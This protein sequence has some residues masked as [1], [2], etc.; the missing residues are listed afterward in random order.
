MRS[1]AAGTGQHDLAVALQ[2]DCVRDFGDTGTAD[3]N[4]F[5]AVVAK[6]CIEEAVRQQPKRTNLGRTSRQHK[7]LASDHDLAIRLD[8]DGVGVRRVS[9]IYAGETFAAQPV[10]GIKV[11]RSR[12]SGDGQRPAAIAA[13]SVGKRCMGVNRMSDREKAA[14]MLFQRQK[15]CRAP[16]H[17]RPVVG[18]FR[19]RDA[20]DLQ[21]NE[22]RLRGNAHR[23]DAI[24]GIA[25]CRPA[26]VAVTV[27]TEYRRRNRR[28]WFF[29]ALAP[30]D[31]PPWKGC[32]AW[33]GVLPPLSSSYGASEPPP[34]P[35]PPSICMRSPRILVMV[36]QRLPCRSTCRTGCGLRY[37]PGAFSDTHRRLPQCGR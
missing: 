21:A 8:C 34:P 23:Y 31:P 14:T 2:C 12:V 26:A 4:Q 37:R 22:C 25:R 32:P 20:Q 16:C 24:A 10:G 35:R 17:L 11:A 5:A 36:F 15:P 19:P 18:P 9:A 27:R 28:A 3:V 1:R 6:R 13:M 7:T 30:L 29:G 33:R